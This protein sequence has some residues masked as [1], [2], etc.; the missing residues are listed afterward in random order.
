MFLHD[1]KQDK[2]VVLIVTLDHDHEAQLANYTDFI[3]DRHPK[4]V[5]YVFLS[6]AASHHE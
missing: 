4:R 6:C 3:L 2:V 5:L 1:D